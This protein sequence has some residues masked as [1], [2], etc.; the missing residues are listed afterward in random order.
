ERRA[1]AR[2]PHDRS[3][4]ANLQP[5]GVHVTGE[6][7]PHV[8]V[9]SGIAE[10]LCN[11]R[12]NSFKHIV[13]RGNRKGSIVNVVEYGERSSWLQRPC[14]SGNGTGRVAYEAEDP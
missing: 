12:Y 3:H 11:S 4:A 13:A 8:R 2:C 5:G 1:G 9:A 7:L 6:Q 14:N 10:G